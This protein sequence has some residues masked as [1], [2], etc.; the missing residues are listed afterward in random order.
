MRINEREREKAGKKYY[1][2]LTFRKELITYA[3]RKKFIRTDLNNNFLRKTR[4]CCMQQFSK[5]INVEG[6]KLLF[7]I[8]TSEF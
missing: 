6:T 7:D 1:N 4:T 5:V 2:Q 8:A 3:C